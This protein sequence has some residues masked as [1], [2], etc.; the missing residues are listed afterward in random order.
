MAFHNFYGF[1][2]NI[3]CEF[4]FDGQ[5]K[6]DRIGAGR[7]QRPEETAVGIA[8]EKGFITAVYRLPF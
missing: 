8:A 1:A 7:K 5:R 6:L 3:K 4:L 2:V